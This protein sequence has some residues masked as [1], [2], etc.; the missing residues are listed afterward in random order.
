MTALPGAGG[1]PGAS[2]SAMT[3]ATA[4]GIGGPSGVGNDRA[5]LTD[6]QIAA[7]TNDANS[8]EIEQAQLAVSKAKDPR[9]KDF[10]AMMIKH[11]TEAKNK[12]A[13][14]GLK[15][16]ASPKSAKLEKD[17]QDTLSKLKS[18]TGKDFDVEYID[19]QVDEHQ[20]VARTIERDLMPNAQNAD[21][22]AY[23]ADIKPTVEAHLEKAKALQRTLEQSASAK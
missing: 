7:I 19:A 18:A 2:A 22:K 8:A 16:A 15:T 10:A 21:L 4:T 3:A 11:H 1:S 9:I 23:L 20:T 6:E 17:A 14:L 5:M 12:Q 13:K